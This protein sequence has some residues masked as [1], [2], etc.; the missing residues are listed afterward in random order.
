MK[1]WCYLQHVIRLARD[2]ASHRH[3][4]ATRR[5]AFRAFLLRLGFTNISARFFSRR[6]IGVRYAGF[7][8]PVF[9]RLTSSDISVASEVLEREEYGAVGQMSIADDATIVDLGGNIGLATIY[10]TK[11][12]LRSRVLIVEP[13]QDNCRMIELNCNRLK[14]EGRL[15]LQRAFAADQDGEAGLVS[16]GE[17]L[18]YRMGDMPLDGSGRISALSMP[19][20]LDR[21]HFDIVHLLKCDIEGAEELLFRDCG[22]WIGRVRNMVVEVHEPYTLEQLYA[23]LASANWKFKVLDEQRRQGFAVCALAG[24]R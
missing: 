8:D 9:L 4:Y 14:A 3:A 19:T 16:C 24:G 18:G 7:P 11:R 21:A 23:S 20:L 13:D 17:D 10:F 15:T 2:T 12:F 22:G 6:L 5:D 1:P